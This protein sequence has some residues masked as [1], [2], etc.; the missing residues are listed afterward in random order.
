MPPKRF[1]LTIG[2]DDLST[3]CEVLAART[4]LS[5]S[6]VKQ[7]MVK[8]AVWLQKSGAKPRRVRRATMPVRAGER[9]IFYYDPAVLE[10][11]PPPASCLLD[12]GHYSIWFKPAGLMTQGTRFGDHCALLRQVELHFGSKRDVYLVHRLDREAAGV[13][14]IAHSRTAA[15]RFSARFRR[16]EIEKRYLVWV[17]G[18]LASSQPAG[19]IE[20]ALDGKEAVTE[21]EAVR[22]DAAADQTL[23]RVRIHTGRYHQIRRHFDLIGFP[24][25]G[26]PRYGKGNKNKRGMQLAAYALA[27]VCPFGNGRVEV[28]VDP[29]KMGIF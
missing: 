21:F 22:C 27:F 20:L 29:E 28:S 2:N 10:L 4:G 19:R 7:A 11:D 14:I 23:V 16:H 1:E 5:K 9:W 8:G 26:D 25:M 24:V 15:A 6:K 13:L 3:A 17:R 18:D 12:Y